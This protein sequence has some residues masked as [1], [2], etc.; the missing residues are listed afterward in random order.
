M[1]NSEIKKITR[2]SLEA[3]KLDDETAV[4]PHGKDF[5]KL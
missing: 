4:I 1:N 2:K 3:L 5:Y